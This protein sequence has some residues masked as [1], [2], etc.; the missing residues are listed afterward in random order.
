MLYDYASVESKWQGKWDSLGIAKADDRPKFFMH[1]AY[2]GVSGYQHV[3]HMRGFSY[4]DMICRYKRMRGYNVFFPL[5]T[6]ATGNQALGFAKKVRNR[7]SKWLS[8]LKENGYPM[9]EIGRMENEEYVVDYFNRDYQENW[10][11]FGFIA[12]YS[13]FTCTIYP[14]YKRFIDW[15]FRKLN[16]HS[17]LTRK[18]YY[19]TFCP[20]CGPVAVDPSETD[21]SKGGNAEK[22]EYTLLKFRFGSDLIVA[23]TLR[24]ETVFGQ[25]NLWVNP[26]QEYVR[27]KVGG[28]IW[29][30]SPQC[31][32]KLKYQKD[33]VEI[34]GKISSSKWRRN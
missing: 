13:S 16:E 21:I 31:A 11:K 3:G 14:E 29:I 34:I 18:P 2:P 24:P 28:E 26:G 32:E 22:Y 15:Q 30:C 1:F 6:H 7:D 25:T 4:T 8:Y 20:N 19:A 33:G 27:V 17:L 5:G 9:G 12:D 23:A 10:R